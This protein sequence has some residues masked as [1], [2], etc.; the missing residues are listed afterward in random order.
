MWL[1]R[2]LSKIDGWTEHNSW[3]Y[4]YLLCRD[5]VNVNHN[6]QIFYNVLRDNFSGE[7]R[8]FGSNMVEFMKEYHR[9]KPE[10]SDKSIIYNLASYFKTY[11]FTMAEGQTWGNSS[12]QVTNIILYG[13]LVV[14]SF[15]FM[16]SYFKRIYY[17]IVLALMAPLIVIYDFF[18]KSFTSK[19]GALGNWFKEFLTLV[20]IQTLQ[21]FIYAFII[22]L[23]LSINFGAVNQVEYRNAGMG[24][25]AVIG[26]ASVFKIEAIVKK[27]IGFGNTKADVK[28]AMSS[29]A[30][31]AIAWQFGKRV[32]DN[33]AKIAGGAG[34]IISSRNAQNKLNRDMK[35]KLSAGSGEGGSDPWNNAVAAAENKS[36]LRGSLPLPSGI[37]G[38]VVSSGSSSG[39]SKNYNDMLESYQDKI[40]ELKK[41]RS[42]GIKQ[43]MK[44]VGE[45]AVAIPGALGGA[46]IGGAS[47][48]L[49]DAIRGASVGA[50][51]GDTIGGFAA[52]TA[53]ETGSAIKT[54]GKTVSSGVSSAYRIH[55]AIK[56]QQIDGKGLEKARNVAKAY[57][58]EATKN[59]ASTR[60]IEDLIKRANDANAD[61]A[62]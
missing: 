2:P 34:S 51:I 13:I 5:A 41:K 37:G 60:E 6:R 35:M 23:I 28:G 12:P 49:D 27:I 43:I 39:S 1:L 53:F 9:P 3:I 31:T 20:F 4:A 50:G 15:M 57:Y 58:K 38:G 54:A 40:A 14:Q 16:M 29:L 21:A 48:E 30:K 46:L 52:D 11:S 18:N 55:K 10:Q 25:F 61:N 7:I 42:D 36:R 47:G 26:L 44:G 33:G 59:R 8:D 32:L 19:G 56:E 24:M 45:T 22:T 17:V 62:N